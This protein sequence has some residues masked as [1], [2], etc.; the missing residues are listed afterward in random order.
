MHAGPMVR[1][2]GA[3]LH[4]VSVAARIL[5]L[6]RQAPTLL[7][8]LNAAFTNRYC[9]STPIPTECPILTFSSVSIL[10]CPAADCRGEW[11][12]CTPNRGFPRPPEYVL[13]SGARLSAARTCSGPGCVWFD[14]MRTTAEDEE[15][16]REEE[17]LVIDLCAI[18]TTADQVVFCSSW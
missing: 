3:P 10:A 16:R 18:F 8:R 11:S 17:T 4:A 1:R 13:R 14:T 5:F 2:R 7:W 9:T 12:A 15:V 6:L